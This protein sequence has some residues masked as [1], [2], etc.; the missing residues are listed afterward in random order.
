[1][2][3]VNQADLYLLAFETDSMRKRER[4]EYLARAPYAAWDLLVRGRYSFDFDLMPMNVPRMKFPKRLNLVRAALN[5]GYRRSTPWSWPL[6]MQIELTSYCNL[7]CPVCPLGTPNFQRKSM[8]MDLELLQRLMGEVGPYLLT[9]ALWAWGEPLLHPQLKEALH[10]VRRYPVLTLLSTNGQNL[11]KEK[12]IQALL[13]E[14]PDYLIVAVDGITDKTHSLFRQGGSLMPI[15]EGVRRLSELKRSKGLKKPLLHCRFMV[16]KHNQD[17]LPQLSGFVRDLGFD[18]L[19][20]RT[21]SIIDA[22]DRTHQQMIPDSPEWCAYTYEAGQ[23]VRRDDF[24]CQHAFS[25]PTVLAD[26]TVLACEQD[27]NGIHSYGVMSPG[28]SFAR[29]WFGKKAAAI[30]RT[31]RD[32]P[33][34]FSFCHNCPYADRPTS[35]CSIQALEFKA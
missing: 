2:L 11:N 18:M 24:I 14:P 6:H 3:H 9:V 4:W 15:R 21:L 8:A 1:M 26:G 23:R 25:F 10:Q 27:F 28:A 35:S 12:V 30:R 22:P 33:H 20:I 13:E 31:I 7:R 32:T 34:Q 19:S 16:M 17:E 5:L 29:L